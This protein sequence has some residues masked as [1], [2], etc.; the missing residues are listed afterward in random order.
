MVA[1]LCCRHDRG[2]VATP[3]DSRRRTITAQGIGFPAHPSGHRTS[4]ASWQG[5]LFTLV[6]IF[7]ALLANV[8]AFS[9]CAGQA[10]Y[11][12]LT[13]DINEK[14]SAFPVH[15]ELNRRPNAFHYVMWG[16]TLGGRFLLKQVPDDWPHS[17][18]SCCAGGE[19]P[20]PNFD[21]LVQQDVLAAQKIFSYL[22][23]EASRDV[24]GSVELDC[25]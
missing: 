24:Q 5:C 4:T 2:T 23:L 6:A 11:R 3:K 10:H 13:Q 21:Q 25:C 1:L 12:A 14:C 19:L 8:F 17:F 20:S 16:S 18:L 7:A 22:L 9:P 15:P